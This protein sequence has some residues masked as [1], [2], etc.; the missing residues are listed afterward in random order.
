MPITR[1]RLDHKGMKEMLK[2]DPVTRV[3]YAATQEV[4]AN[5]ESNMSSA[6]PDLDF[7]VN[8]LNFITDRTSYVIQVK[9]PRAIHFEGKY[10]ILTRAAASAGLEV[11]EK[12]LT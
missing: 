6:V 3:I 4:V 11:K 12:P 1:L 7:E 2:S 10:G 8:A 5:A 9:H